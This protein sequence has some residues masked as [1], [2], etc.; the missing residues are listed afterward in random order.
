MYLTFTLIPANGSYHRRD[1]ESYEYRI[2]N[3]ESNTD[4][5]HKKKVTQER[6]ARIQSHLDALTEHR[7]HEERER[8][9]SEV[10]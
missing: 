9:L 6:Q 8:H 3:D 4:L 7:R 1:Y 5:F 10:C 2:K